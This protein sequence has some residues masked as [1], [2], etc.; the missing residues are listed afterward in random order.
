[1]G[2][3]STLE[4][5]GTTYQSLRN[6]E[7]ALDSYEESRRISEDIGDKPGIA[8]TLAAKGELF[9]LRGAF[10]EAADMESKASTIAEEI[11][12]PETIRYSRTIAGKAFRALKKPDLAR[13]A[14]EDAISAVERMSSN[15]AGGEQEENDFFE[16]KGSPYQEMVSLLADQNEPGQALNYAERARGRVLRDV[17]EN[18]RIHITKAMS[19]DEISRDRQLKSQLLSR[20]AEI[21]RLK[22]QPKRDE[23]HLAELEDRLNKV[24]LEIEA[25]QTSLYAAHPELQSQRGQAPPL[26]LGDLNAF[27][28]SAPN[29]AFLEYVVT[30][31]R[32]ILIVITRGTRGRSD[33]LDMKVYPIG[34][35]RH[36]LEGM[37][38]GFRRLVAERNLSI[39][40]KAGA[41]YDVLI[42]P[43][44]NELHDVSTL[45]ILPDGPLWQLPFQVL[46][47][48]RGYLLET[49]S[50]YYAHSLTALRDASR[51]RSD[52]RQTHSRPDRNSP[53][54]F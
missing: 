8:E 18:G 36:D 21:S 27:S 35:T 23:S 12:L 49:Y 3:A 53:E 20:E 7:M 13:K 16:D 10:A 45:C 25:F 26:T 31:D 2:T 28:R 39:K 17:V 38:D 9:Y 50:I 52:R 40:T 37:V 22:L 48:S 6:Y 44:E 19:K 5:I 14:F 1:Q 51:N 33:S 47:H 41:L 4:N 43:V 54:L 29:T 24:R 34:V 30:D 11:G 42:K 32:T 46:Y 15:V